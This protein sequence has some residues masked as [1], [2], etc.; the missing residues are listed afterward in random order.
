MTASGA[1]GSTSSRSIP[2]VQMLANN[3]SS[4]PCAFTLFEY[5][6]LAAHTP[7]L[8]DGLTANDLVRMT[9]DRYLAGAKGY[10]QVGY[11][12]PE[13]GRR[14]PSRLEDALDLD[15]TRCRRSSSPPATTS[16]ARATWPGRGP[17]MTS[18]PRG[19]ARCS[20]PTRTATASSNIPA[21]ATSA[22]AH[23]RT[24]GRPI[25]GTRSTSAM[26][27]PSPTRS[28][29]AP[30]RCSPV[31]RAS[32]STPT[33]P[34]SSPRKPPS[35][36]PPTCRP[37][38][39]PRRAC[40]PAGRARTASCTITGS[41]LSR[42]WPSPSACWTTRRPT[43]SWT[44][45][46]PR[47]QEVGYTDFSLGLPGNLVPVRK[48]DYVHRE[49]SARGHRRAAARR[50]Q[51]RLPVLRERRRDRLLGL[52]HR[53]GAL[54]AR[55]RRRTPAASS[56]RCWPAT[57][58][59]SSRASCDDGM[60]RDWRDWKGGCHGY[61]GLLVDNYHALLAVLDDVKAKR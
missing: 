10:G 8:A 20:P 60:S 50:R 51:R 54:S 25:G 41:R 37:S 56:I 32:W 46:W 48:G 11:T 6:D 17:T 31:S 53:Q 34:I 36:A 27:T 61:E 5:S 40:S 9:L 23:E 12:D 7:P 55:P 3:A 28:P 33:T 18:W 24:D 42:A 29:T 2:R 16:R 38:S 59:A 22:T 4:D 26:R 52:L 47:W 45:C 35:S 49:L 44:G 58:A 13:L 39:I 15:W 43:T 1:T 19:P 21:P 30:R 14:G 57:R